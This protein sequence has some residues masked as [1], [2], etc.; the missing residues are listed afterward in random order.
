MALRYFLPTTLLTATF[1]VSPDAAAESA[2]PQ[3]PTTA[4]PQSPPPPPSSP[5]PPQAA[6]PSSLSRLIV[7]GTAPPV[8]PQLEPPVPYGNPP[9]QYM[10]PAV[11]PPPPLLP[12]QGAREHDGFYLRL[13]L[14]GGALG[15]SFGSDSSSE[16]HGAFDGSFMHGS[17]SFELN[18][19]GTPAP[20]LVIGGGVWLDFAIGQPQSTDIR[21]NGKPAPAL[22]LDHAEIGLL[23]P[24][25]DYYFDPKQGFHVEGAL[26]IAWMNL[27]KG[28]RGGAVT[29]D[30]KAM[31]GLGFMLG[32]GY[33]WWIA[34]QWSLGALLRFLY[35][36]T[37]S[38]RD[39][40]EVWMGKGYA[41]P[42][43]LFGATYH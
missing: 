4:A 20:G 26:G 12:P 3:P 15:G 8:Q 41:F 13:G 24:F 37:E 34:E 1:A 6:T 16:L 27:G 33:E 32:G 5:P 11:Y 31:G 28:T 35:V 22:V 19:G 17:L 43:I 25:V 21:V 30:E 42:E 14:G 38:N 9:G 10:A 18:I 23:G 7:G 2:A 39:D 36:S 40:S 29:S